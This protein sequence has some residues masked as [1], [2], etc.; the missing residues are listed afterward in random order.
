MSKVRKVVIILILMCYAMA[1]PPMNGIY[2]QVGFV[3]G[4]PTFMFGLLVNALLPVLLITFLFIYE[5]KKEKE[6]D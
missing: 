3:C 1:F 6:L 5:S 4:I 2:N